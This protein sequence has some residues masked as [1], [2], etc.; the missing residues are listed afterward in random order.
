MQQ[1]RE[2]IVRQVDKGSL[3][4]LHRLAGLSHDQAISQ[5]ALPRMKEDLKSVQTETS[6]R[7][8]RVGKAPCPQTRSTTGQLVM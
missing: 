4:G 7:K 5:V 8:E 3:R 2:I 1:E 6:E